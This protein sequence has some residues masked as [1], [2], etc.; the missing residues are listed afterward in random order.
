MQRINHLWILVPL[1]ATACG[2]APELHSTTS[3]SPAAPPAQQDPQTGTETPPPPLP[4][5]PPPPAAPPP[6]APPPPPPAAHARGVTRPY[7][8]AP[9]GEAWTM[10]SDPRADR[11]FDPQN[12]VTPNADGSWKMQSSKVR[13]E[14]FTSTGYDAGKIT[15]DRGTLADRG[16]MQAPNDW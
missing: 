12:T 9:G 16:Y 15:T 4:P 10:P 8:A 13:M 14:V 6:A 11:R 2:S 5:A 3:S 1:L 7:P